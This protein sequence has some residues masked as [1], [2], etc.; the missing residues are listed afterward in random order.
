MILFEFNRVF[1]CATSTDGALVTDWVTAPRL[2]RNLSPS[3]NMSGDSRSV[4]SQKSY[5]IPSVRY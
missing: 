4:S 5:S 1:L 2:I 3:L